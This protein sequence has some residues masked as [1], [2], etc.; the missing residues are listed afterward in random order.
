MSQETW[1]MKSEGWHEA[2]PARSKGLRFLL[3]LLIAEM[4]YS[5]LRELANGFVAGLRFAPGMARAA[6]DAPEAHRALI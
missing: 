3:A 1:K 6:R 5:G 2:K 4:T